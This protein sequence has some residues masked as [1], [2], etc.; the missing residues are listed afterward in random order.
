[1][2][3]GIIEDGSPGSITRMFPST[4]ACFLLILRPRAPLRHDQPITCIPIRN[5]K[6]NKKNITVG[7]NIPYDSDAGLS[8]S[9]KI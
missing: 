8:L 4:H 7:R 6:V 1:M 9:L 3:F 5:W 2:K